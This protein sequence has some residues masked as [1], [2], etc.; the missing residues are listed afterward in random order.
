MLAFLIV[1][2]TLAA[3]VPAPP[4]GTKVEATTYTGHFEKNTS[5]LKGETS[6]L[7]FADAESFGTVFG[8]VPPLIGRGGEPAERRCR[9]TPSRRAWSLP[10][11]N[12]KT[13]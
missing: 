6:V 13:R 1:S 4:A 8:T 9:P 5:G 3:P 10:S 12:A 2:S 7:A 11:S